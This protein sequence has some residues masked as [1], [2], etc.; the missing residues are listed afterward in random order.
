MRSFHGEGK[1]RSYFEGWYLKQQNGT[2]TV[3][4]IPAFHV[5]ETGLASASLQIISGAGAFWLPFPAQEFSA[6]RKEFLVRLGDCVFSRYGCKLDVH[7]EHCVLEGALRFGP[8]SPPARDIMGPFRFAP[9]LQCR[10]SVFSLYHRVSG[11]LTLNGQSIRFRNGSGYFEGDRG[12]S[13]PSRYVWTHC[14]RGGNCVM[15]SVAEIPFAGRSFTGCIGS[16]FVDGKEHR[17]ATYRGVRLLEIGN[18][19]I[20]LRQ[21]N[22]TLQVSL[23]E[24]RPLTLHAPAGGS[25]TRL[26]RESASCRVRYR[27]TVADSV[28]FD[29]VGEQ[30]SF[31]SNWTDEKDSS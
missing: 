20:L 23:L 11:E 15:L 7:T 26:I 22:L 17:I 16:L 1:R 5:D 10:H 19:G 31:E 9:F 18:R 4:L 21:G 3:A 6:N 27:C 12:T 30:A 8:F 2:D 28:W 14:C 24:S 29:F 25:M 13:F